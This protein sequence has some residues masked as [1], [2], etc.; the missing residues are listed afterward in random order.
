MNDFINNSIYILSVMCYYK[1]VPRQLH[2]PR[3][4]TN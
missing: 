4:T 1:D 3:Y 2:S